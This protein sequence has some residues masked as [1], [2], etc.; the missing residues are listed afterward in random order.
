M[1]RSIA[2]VAGALIATG[3]GPQSETAE[4][5]PPPDAEAPYAEA[6]SPPS[7]HDAATTPDPAGEASA[8]SAA[9]RDAAGGVD[10]QGD[11]VNNVTATAQNDSRDAIKNIA[12]SKDAAAPSAS[13][14]GA[15]FGALVGDEARGKRL[16]AQCMACHAVAEGQNRVGPTLYNIVGSPAG[17]VPGF[18]YSDANANSD[19]VW[20]EDALF[21]FLEDPRGYMPG[22]RMIFQGVAKPQDRADIVAYL[23]TVSE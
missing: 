20:T 16:Y 7:H 4:T 19:V 12:V 1:K 14:D 22:T 11:K 15:G 13:D 6:A 23:K 8:Q 18:R 21:A 9:F 2:F 5:L 10:A 3:C 17:N